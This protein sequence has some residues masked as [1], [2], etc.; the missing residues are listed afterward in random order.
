MRVTWRQDNSLKCRL[1]FK[2]LYY[3]VSLSEGVGERE[4][5][6]EVYP[7]LSERGES[8]MLPRCRNGVSYSGLEEGDGKTYT[9]A[10]GGGRGDLKNMHHL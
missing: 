10:P 7:M 6:L 4:G 8:S 9:N 1:H 2:N 3:P 5:T